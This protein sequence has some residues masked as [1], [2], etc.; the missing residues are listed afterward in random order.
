MVETSTETNADNFIFLSVPRC[1]G[2][3]AE[4]GFNVV[5]QKAA[6][7]PE[8]KSCAV[9]DGSLSVFAAQNAISYIC[10]ESDGASG[11]FRQRQM[12]EA[13]YG[14]LPEASPIEILTAI[15]RK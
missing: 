3:F 10:L 13:V 14:L 2:Y 9:D 15:S 4:F 12:L 6:A 7:K 11:A 5:V 8:S 1:V